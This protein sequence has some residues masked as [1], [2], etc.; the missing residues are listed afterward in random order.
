MSFL[1]GPRRRETACKGVAARRTSDER[2]AACVVRPARQ[3][4]GIVLLVRRRLFRPGHRLIGD[5]QDGHY[6]VHLYGEWILVPDD[7]VVTEPNKFG[8]S[9]VWPYV[10]AEGAMRIRCFL[11]GSGT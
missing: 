3:Q 10:D 7:A 11:P 1:D 2:A 6:R 8:P 4:K 9:V 5:T